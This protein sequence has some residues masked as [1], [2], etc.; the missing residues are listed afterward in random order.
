[1]KL[2]P[3]GEN[4]KVVYAELDLSGGNLKVVPADLDPQGVTF[5]GYLFQDKANFVE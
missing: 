4:L 3:S 5:V 1:L 2:A